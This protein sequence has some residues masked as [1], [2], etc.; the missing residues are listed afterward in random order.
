[1]RALSRVFDELIRVPGTNIRFGLDSL[2]GLF[3]A[4]GDLVGG[5]VSAYALVVASRLGAPASVLARMVLNI[6]IDTIVGTIPLVGDA[7]DVAWKANR[8]NLE[9]LER[10]EREPQSTK[11]SSIAVLAIALLFLLLLIVA[12]AMITI[13]IVRQ[14]IALLHH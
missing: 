13:W 11:R 2:I 12:A 7:F 1:M 3:P 9:L 10:F 14:L 8:K 6:A 4:G 5:L